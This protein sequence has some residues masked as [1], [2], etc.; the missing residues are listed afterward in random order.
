[1][2]ELF[3]WT[4]TTLYGVLTFTVPTTVPLLFW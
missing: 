1:M 2:Y 3:A 4:R